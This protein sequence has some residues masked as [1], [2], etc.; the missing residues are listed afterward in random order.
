MQIIF[1]QTKLIK[2]LKLNGLNV[3][4]SSN[5]N[6]MRKCAN[7]LLNFAGSSANYV[8]DMV[9]LVTQKRIAIPMKMSVLPVDQR[10]VKKE[11]ADLR[12]LQAAQALRRVIH[13][14]NAEQ[15]NRHLASR[16]RR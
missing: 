10:F 2:K 12:H 3:S 15:K 13:V 8:T 6:A 5:K 14:K 9:T 7:L 4:S 11:E 1:S 16:D